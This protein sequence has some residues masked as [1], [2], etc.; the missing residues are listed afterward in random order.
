MAAIFRFPIF[1]PPS[2]R[3]I[4]SSPIHPND[5]ASPTKPLSVA[6]FLMAKTIVGGTRLL[7]TATALRFRANR[8]FMRAASFRW[9][10]AK[11]SMS[12]I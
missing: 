2:R 12:R 11:A 1:R 6:G 7:H 8:Q 9:P 10:D 5:P 4:P 3:R